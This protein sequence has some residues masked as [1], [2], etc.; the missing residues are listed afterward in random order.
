MLQTTAISLR[1]RMVLMAKQNLTWPE[2]WKN[3]PAEAEIYNDSNPK[4]IFRAGSS[5][6]Y[7]SGTTIAAAVTD[8][9]AGILIGGSL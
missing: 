6:E 2:N 4:Q 3:A 9:A 5:S 1:E 7:I 8:G